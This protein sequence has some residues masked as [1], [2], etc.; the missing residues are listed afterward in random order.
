MAAAGVIPSGDTFDADISIRQSLVDAKGQLIRTPPAVAMHITR[1]LG[2]TGTWKTTL[3]LTGHDKPSVKSGTTVKQLD[4]PFLITR[5]EY[6]GDGSVPRL[7]NALGQPVAGPTEADRLRLKST[8]PP[9]QAV[10]DWTAVHN[11]LSTP[12]IAAST[13]D[14]IDHVIATPAKR[15]DRRKAIESKFGKAKGRVNGLDR[16]VLTEGD[17]V[18][19]MLVN[20]D[21]IV[22]VELNSVEKG[23]LVGRTMFGYAPG[24]SGA[25][26]RRLTHAERA[27]PEIAGARV[28]TDLELTNVVVVRGA[29]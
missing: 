7:F 17:A 19:E 13:S 8:V 9:G 29:Q 16:H 24:A 14:W 12:V 1:S 3:T 2:A 18:H 22:P 10:I 11:Q 28:V 21:A 25:L 27:V 23:V 6:D 20:P 5:M 4:N 15:P 26:I